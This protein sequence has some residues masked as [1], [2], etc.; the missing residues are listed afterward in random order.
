[1]LFVGFC[2]AENIAMEN[3]QKNK[4]LY[5][6]FHQMESATS[7]KKQQGAPTKRHVLISR[8]LLR[9][10]SLFMGKI[11]DSRSELDA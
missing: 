3:L 8:I 1:M 6:Y 9:W 5:A 7:A 4:R 2:Q 10:Q 11:S